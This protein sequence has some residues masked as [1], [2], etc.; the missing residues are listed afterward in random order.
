MAT[1]AQPLLMTEEAYLLA[2]ESADYK[3]EYIDGRVY[4]MAGAKANHNR[5]A[6]NIHGAFHAHLK[7]KPCQPY[8]S[9]MKVKIGSKF[10]YPDV[11][12]DCSTLSGDSVYTDH[13]TLIVEVL[14]A[15]TRRLDE[16]TKRMA[17]LQIPTLLEYVLIEQEFVKVEVL[18]RSEGWM[19]ARY[20]LGDE[21]TFE[22]IGLTVP[23]ADL[24][25]RVE[26]GDMAAW[27]RGVEGGRER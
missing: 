12:V 21:V 8:V 18:R 17:Y 19:P 5:I 25:D 10:F 4:A 7:G 9:D 27:V 24:Y 14:S 15:S 2:E 26:N 20:Y 13:P 23:V 1:A 11:L 6:G 22:S 16:T 3:S